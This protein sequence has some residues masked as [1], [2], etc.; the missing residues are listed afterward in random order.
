M[1]NDEV[2]HRTLNVDNRLLTEL[3]TLHRLLRPGYILRM[4]AHH[5]PSRVLFALGGQGSKK[6][7]S[8]GQVMT[9][10]QALKLPEH[11]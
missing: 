11:I 10:R 7:R 1:S 9:W 2:R 4:P 8:G 3:I 5:L 6:K